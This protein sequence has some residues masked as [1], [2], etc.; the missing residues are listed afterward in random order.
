ME[1]I[2]DLPEIFDEFEDKKKQSF[3]KVKEYKEKKAMKQEP[4]KRSFYR[5]EKKAV[6]LKKRKDV[7][8]IRVSKD[9]SL[10]NKLWACFEILR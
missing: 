1:I 5:S 9:A 7:K 10:K 6:N 2:K 3:L 4:K 8:T